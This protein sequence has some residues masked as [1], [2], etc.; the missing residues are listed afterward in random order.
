MGTSSLGE[1]AA[2][3]FWVDK[4]FLP[5]RWS[6]V[7]DANIVEE[8]ATLL[9]WHQNSRSLWGT[10]ESHYMALHP[11]G[12]DPDIVKKFPAFPRT[13]RFITALT[14]IRHLS[15]SWASPIQSIYPHHTS[16]RFIPILS[17]PIRDSK[18]VNSSGASSS[19]QKHRTRCVN[20]VWNCFQGD[21]SY[22]QQV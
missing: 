16:C 7:L 1:A 21:I 13:Q 15:L 6:L 22:W 17:P 11:E 4:T 14:S 10:H 12:H 19:V 20:L 9:S 2:F 5:W 3:I 8:P 18:T